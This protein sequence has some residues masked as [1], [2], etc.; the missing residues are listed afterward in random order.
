MTLISPDALH[1]GIAAALEASSTSPE[2]AH[3]VAAALTKAEI[4][5]KKGHG[6]SR[7]PS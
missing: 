5:G 1:A 3:S 7:V 2:N 6:L 4:D